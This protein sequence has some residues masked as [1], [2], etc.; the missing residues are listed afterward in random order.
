MSIMKKIF[1]NFP[2]PRRTVIKPEKTIGVAGTSVVN[3]FIENQE[4]NPRLADVR[5]Y[6]TYSDLLANISIVSAGTR[7]FLNLI[8][9]ANWKV[10]P[11]DESDEAEKFAELVKD[12]MNTM[13]M[14]WSRIIRRAAMYRFYGFSIQEWTA[15]PPVDGIIKINRIAARPQITIERWDIDEHGIVMGV[16][17]RTPLE[18]EERYL[19][20]AKI[21]YV[22]D[23]A[24]N[25]SPEGLGL[26]RHIVEPSDRLKR[27]EQLEG[28]GFE[29]DLRG[30]PIGRAPFAAL[31][32]AVSSGLLTEKEKAEIEQPIKD[33]IQGHIKNP[34][35]GI[36]MDSLTYQSQGEDGKP[37]NVPQWDISLLKGSSTSLPDMANA[38]ERVNRDIA[39]ILG[40][41]GLLLGEQTTGSHALSKDK[42]QNFAL[43]VDSTNDEIADSMQSDFVNVLFELNGWPEE[44]K[45]TLKPEA[46]QHRDVTT[47]TQALKDMSDAGSVMAQDDPANNDIRAI[48]GISPQGGTVTVEN[49]SDT[50]NNSNET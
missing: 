11:A 50:S 36:L 5:K 41:E 35:L 12:N 17:Q 45:P 15:S 7:Y 24:L 47:I 34:E 29:S 39:R 22:V 32:E 23:D 30:I 26:F 38:I 28:Y 44:M 49:T 9:K 2:F 10:I 14:S 18:G 31:S 1:D 3:G 40:V 16:G 46:V 37:S 20:R 13:D 25:D 27:Y 43:I 48:L 4:K 19:P 6:Q 8:A 33:F 21:I 42:S